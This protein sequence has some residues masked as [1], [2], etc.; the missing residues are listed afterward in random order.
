MAAD[1][2]AFGVPSVAATTA[3][4]RQDDSLDFGG[5]PLP[6]E[7]PPDPLGDGWRGPPGPPGPPGA[8]GAATPATTLPLIEAGTGAIG[9]S[10]AY[11]RAD[12]VHPAFG[13][14]GG[15]ASLVIADAPPATP[16]IGDMWFDSVALQTYVRYNDGTS[17]QWVPLLSLPSPAAA[18]TLPLLE[19]GVGA[20][21]ASLA[22]AR[23]D[24]VH[25]ATAGGGG[26]VTK[27][28]TSGTGISGGPITGAGT[29]T[30]AW[31]A[32][33]VSSLSGLTLAG[34]VLT[35][36]PAAAS[37][38]GALTYAQL[39]T[40]VQQLPI[41][42][43]FSGKPATGAFVNVPMSM[44][45]TV[46]SGLAGTVVY[47]T[48]QSSAN[49]D[50]ILNKISGGTTTAIGTIRITSAT[51]TSCALTGSG[52]SLAIGDVLQLVAPTQDATL[53][54]VGITVLCARV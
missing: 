39:P 44:A 41:S 42:F 29:L 22:Y 32:G 50:F 23:A 4:H 17:V 18:T 24:H 49:A 47:D 16:A 19:A 25:P 34:G 33:A 12:H 1:G 13:G 31:N 10:L 35:A 52:G 21:G 37:I 11:A 3:G 48:T 38:T 2:L 43:P 15:G 9:T 14:G 28:D 53:S 27:V 54:D 6:P 40:E 45:I 8:D 30:V 51:H 36:A 20:I 26:T 5:Y 7:V 46:P